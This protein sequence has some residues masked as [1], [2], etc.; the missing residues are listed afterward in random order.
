MNTKAIMGAVGLLAAAPAAAWADETIYGGPPSQ[1]FT[2]TVSP[3]QGEP[4]SFTNLDF[5]DH[6]VVAVDK[7]PDGAPLFRS[8]LVARGGSSVVKGTEFLKTGSYAFFC[9]LH[10]S[11]KGSIDVTEAGTPAARPGSAPPSSP[12]PSSPP[13]SSAPPPSAGPSDTAPPSLRI[14]VADSRLSVV[15][16]RRALRLAITSDEAATVG[17]AVRAGRRTLGSTTTRIESGTTTV[18][19][20]LRRAATSRLTVRATAA[21]AADNTAK[22]TARKT[23]RR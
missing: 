5:V 20:K 8:E 7:G 16:K 2:P 17:L 4:V 18:T 3:D 1:Y 19:V 11:M 14:R 12:P 9:S 21:D 15:R 23:L 6:D 13:P 10:A 22:T